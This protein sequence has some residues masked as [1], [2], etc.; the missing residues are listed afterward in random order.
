MTNT[1][2]LVQALQIT[3]IGMGLVF[4]G[5]LILWGLMEATV[6]LTAWY[7]RSHPEE[8]EGE[9]EEAEATAEE[10]PAAV[11]L[12]ASTDLKQKAAAAAVAI[13]LAIDEESAPVE[14]AAV[15]S[16]GYAAQPSAWQSVMRSAQ[17]NQRSNHFTRKP[18]GSA[19]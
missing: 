2:T 13:A 19:R 6:Q 9:E 15:H 4:V 5:L 10:A 18:R 1:D 16:N 7:N 8:E 3:L 12:P 11:A 17:L 14:M